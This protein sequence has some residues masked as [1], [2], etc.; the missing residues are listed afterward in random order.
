MAEAPSPPPSPDFFRVVREEIP[1][2]R[3]ESEEMIRRRLEK[4]LSSSRSTAPVL[5][6]TPPPR[7]NPQVRSVLSFPQR[8]VAI[9]I[10][11]LAEI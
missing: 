9:E 1:L 8:S 4:G 6:P 11:L 5:Q 2:S 10:S 7:P 3:R